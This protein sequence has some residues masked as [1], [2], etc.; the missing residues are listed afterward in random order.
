LST[1]DF[2]QAVIFNNFIQ[3]WNKGPETKNI[4]LDVV[5]SG[6][7]DDQLEVRVKSSQVQSYLYL[8]ICILEIP[9]SYSFF[10]LQID[11]LVFHFTKIISCAFTFFNF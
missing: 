1:L 2:L 10:K 5:G 8:E 11:M 9:E 3:I 4:V 7:I 6:L